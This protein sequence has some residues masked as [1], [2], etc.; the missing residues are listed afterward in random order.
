[1]DARRFGRLIIAREDIAEWLALGPDP[2]TDG[3]DARDLVRTLH[4]S[5]RTIKDAIMD[6]GV[7]AGI[8]NILATEA[9]W[10]AGIDPRSTS[11]ALSRRDVAAIVRA[12][13][14][15]IAKE[16]AVTGSRESVCGAPGA[17]AYTVYGRAGQPCRRCGATVSRVTLGGRTTAFCRK[18]QRRRAPSSAAA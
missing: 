1:V 18:C 5:T 8:G 15:A 4:A 10:R 3:I 16:L 13:M 17:P 14:A 2:L 6:Q 7:M 9:L 11:S 12:L